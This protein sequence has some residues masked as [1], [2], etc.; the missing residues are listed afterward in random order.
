MALLCLGSPSNPLSTRGVPLRRLFA[1][2]EKHHLRDT[3]IAPDRPLAQ[4][5]QQLA[6]TAG[7]I[8]INGQIF[9]LAGFGFLA[10]RFNP[11]NFYF[12]YSELEKLQCVIA[13]VTNTPWREQYCY[14]L[15][16]RTLVEPVLEFQCD[17]AF[18][19]SPFMP[20]DTRYCWRIT[21][22]GDQLTINIAVERANQRIFNAGFRLNRQPL[23]RFNLIIGMLRQPLMSVSVLV[24]IYWQAL[25]L[26]LK[27]VPFYPH[28]R[29]S[30]GDK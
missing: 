1:F 4:R 3:G 30:A 9:L 25:R 20:M 15:D 12:C 28:P 22:P 5:V 19:V 17:K 7:G 18:H 21:E 16:A 24:R 11:V 29:Y 27:S 8:V 23:S 13:E 2:S 26:W 14:L 6:E 10:H